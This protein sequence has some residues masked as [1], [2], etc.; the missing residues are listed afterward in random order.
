VDTVNKITFL[1]AL[2]VLLQFC[3]LFVL[4]PMAD[5]VSALLKAHLIVHYEKIGKWKYK[6]NTAPDSTATAR[7]P[8]AVTPLR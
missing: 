8:V 1:L 7:G 4:Y 5:N 6:G 3:S 2:S